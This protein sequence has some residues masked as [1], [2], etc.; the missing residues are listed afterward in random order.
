MKQNAREFAES[1]HGIFKNVI[2]ALDGWLVKIQK[3][4]YNKETMPNPPSYYSRKGYHALNVQVIVN[5]RKK[6]LWRSIKARGG[7]HDSAV[8]KDTELLDSLTKSHKH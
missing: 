7:A 4:V 8:F 1:S 3:P 2:G 6:I 5:K